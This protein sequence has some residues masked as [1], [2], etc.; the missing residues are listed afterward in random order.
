MKAEAQEYNLFG[1]EKEP[2]CHF[3][4]STRF[5]FVD[6]LYLLGSC[7]GPIFPKL[8]L[9]TSFL[10]VRS[11]FGTKRSMEMDDLDFSERRRSFIVRK[12]IQIFKCLKEECLYGS[13]VI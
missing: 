10:T 2:K 13:I 5:D 6:D 8:R 11:Q 1:P 9:V 12:T 7:A 3:K 4:L